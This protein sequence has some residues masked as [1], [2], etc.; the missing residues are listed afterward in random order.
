MSIQE[1]L[2]AELKA[3]TLERDQKRLDVIRAIEGEIKLARTAKGFEGEVDDALYLKIIASYSKKMKK[4]HAEYEKAGDRGKDLAD[5]LAFEVDY[6][7]RWLPQKLDE[8]ATLALVLSTIA[9]LGVDDPKQTGRVMGAIMKDHGKAVDGGLVSK[10][11]AKQL[12]KTD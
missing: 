12:K 9:D 5:T 1:E 7:S 6:L 8:E 10:L 11:V 3:A 2:R 4:A